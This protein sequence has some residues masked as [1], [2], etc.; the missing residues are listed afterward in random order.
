MYVLMEGRR[1]RN[2]MYF[3]RLSESDESLQLQYLVS[4]SRD[5]HRRVAC[6]LS[7]SLLL[8]LRNRAQFTECNCLL[9][10]VSCSCLAT[11]WACSFPFDHRRKVPLQD[12]SSLLALCLLQNPESPESHPR[13]S[14]TIM[15][16]WRPRPWGEPGI[17]SISGFAGFAIV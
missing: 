12:S 1:C 9:A 15:L 16:V 14:C 11:I 7:Q 17:N 2:V 13:S 3:L 5:L 8:L 4:I 6:Y 10:V